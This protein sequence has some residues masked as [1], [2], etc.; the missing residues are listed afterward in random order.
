MYIP[1][2]GAVAMEA[3]HILENFDLAGMDPARRA[4]VVGRAL[5][6]AFRDW[7]LQGPPEAAAR[8]TSKAFAA[9][10][11]HEL[12]EAMAGGADPAEM[13]RQGLPSEGRPSP[14]EAPRGLPGSVSFQDH[15]AGSHT[16]HLSTAD[17]AGMMVALTQTLGP[18]MGSKVATPG[19]GFLYASTLGGYLGD[20]QPGERAR[21]FICPFLVTRGDEPLLVLGAAGGS[22]IPVAVVNAIVH[23]VDEGLSF[24]EAVAAPR[25]APG[26]GSG[27]SMET[28]V[29]AGWTTEVVEAVRG[30]GLEIREVPR[31]ASFGRIH[32]IRFDSQ[33][34]TW[35]G[36]ADPDWQGTA[37]GA[38]RRGGGEL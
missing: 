21:S 4:A 38:R 12:E 32:G 14:W 13:P 28:H 10:R 30:M 23:F 19:L 36:V 35:V 11:A 24:P 5:G 34:G 33:S 29:G 8:V 3:L 17:G 31:E 6:I 18:V 20:M 7:Q 25:I 9:Q 15:F 37:L 1:T 2:A 16:T 26:F 22:M 27:Y